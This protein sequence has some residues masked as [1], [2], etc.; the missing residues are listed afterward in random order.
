MQRAEHGNVP[1]SER[2]GFR[3]PDSEHRAQPLLEGEDLPGHEVQLFQEALCGKPA[4]GR[5]DG[6]RRLK[7]LAAAATDQGTGTLEPEPVLGQGGMDPVLQAGALPGQHH[8]GAG[9][10]PLVPQ[11]TGRDPHGGERPGA[12]E[13][14]QPPRVELIGLVHHAEHK[15]RLPGVDQLRDLAGR[16]DLI[17]DPVPVPDGLD[18]HRRAGLAGA[19]E[20]LQGTAGVRDPALVPA[21]PVRRLH[22]HLGIPIMGI[23]GDVLHK[24]PVTRT[25]LSGFPHHRSPRRRARAPLI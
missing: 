5:E 4:M 18:R 15:L 13:P 20:P 9:E 16:F 6:E 17:H 7:P 24:R 19:Q 14:V 1:D 11:G 3:I 21:F 22:R 12:L 10:I 2:P 8:A 23:E 25:P